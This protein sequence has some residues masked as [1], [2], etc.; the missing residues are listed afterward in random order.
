MI[1]EMRETYKKCSAYLETGRKALTRKRR[2][3]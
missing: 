1:E 3:N 2:S